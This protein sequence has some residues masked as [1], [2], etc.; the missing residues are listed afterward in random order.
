M[1]IIIILLNNVVLVRSDSFR[2]FS[3]RGHLKKSGVNH[4]YIT[5]KK[6]NI[7]IIVVISY[8]VNNL[9]K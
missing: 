8:D 9:I 5:L 1:I 2:Q 6:T 7:L 4:I 3:Q